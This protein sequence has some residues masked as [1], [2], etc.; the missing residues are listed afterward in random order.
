MLARHG[1]RAGAGKAGGTSPPSAVNTGSTAV[2][3]TRG[4][5]E[6]CTGRT[7]G[8]CLDSRVKHTYLS[9]PEVALLAKL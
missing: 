6:A 5:A 9:I 1:A 7:G 4:T 8:A 3:Y 2:L